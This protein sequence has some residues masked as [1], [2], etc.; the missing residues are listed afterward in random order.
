MNSWAS[1]KGNW[2]FTS[3]KLKVSGFNA[4][5]QTFTVL[6]KTPTLLDFLIM[7]SHCS[8]LP[9]YKLAS[10]VS[11]VPFLIPLKY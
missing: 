3:W 2:F 4:T 6:N 8:L 7:F 11:S 9:C 5:E 1:H 10:L